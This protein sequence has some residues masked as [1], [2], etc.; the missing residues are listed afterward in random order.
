MKRIDVAVG[1]ITNKRGELL[2]GQRIVKDRYFKKWEFPGGKLETKET[3]K[4]ALT[5]ELKEELGIN[6]IDI[7]E[8]ITLSHDYS[9]RQ[10]K[11]FVQK[12]ISYQGVPK[13]IEGQALKW[14]QL[15]KIKNLDMLEG[16]YQI[17][18][19][20]EPINFKT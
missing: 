4:E 20:L 7:H 15:N 6:V 10:V 17:I 8:M 12:V 5:R 16:N 9:D 19:F 11:L 3:A 2:V 13:G 14:V 1:I 18:E